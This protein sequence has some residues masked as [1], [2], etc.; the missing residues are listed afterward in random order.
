MN[1]LF[2]KGFLKTAEPILAKQTSTGIEWDKP[3]EH[4]AK[5]QALSAYYSGEK[6]ALRKRKGAV[7]EAPTSDPKD[8]VPL[9]GVSHVS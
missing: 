6:D 5:R 4:R 1:D 2:V 8:S 7:R 3:T 9:A